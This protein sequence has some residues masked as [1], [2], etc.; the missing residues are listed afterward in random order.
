MSHG[1]RFAKL[2][3]RDLCLVET[4]EFGGP[5]CFPG[6]IN[7]DVVWKATSDRVER[8]FGDTVPPGDFGAFKGRFAD[9]RCI[10]KASAREIGFAFKT[11]KLDSDGFYASIGPEKNGVFL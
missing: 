2:K 1:G 10:A 7:C 4:F 8:G 5:F 11:G 6:R 9:A 3:I